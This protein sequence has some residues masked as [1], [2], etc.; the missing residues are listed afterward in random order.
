MK[1]VEAA[2]A[3]ALQQAKHQIRQLWESK[4]R[5]SRNDLQIVMLSHFLV[6]LDR[7]RVERELQRDFHVNASRFK[8]EIELLMAH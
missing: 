8:N 1:S 5:L 7:G 6:A 3:D 2:F 4:R